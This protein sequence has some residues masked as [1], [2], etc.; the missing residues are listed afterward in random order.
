[1]SDY[2]ARVL[3]LPKQYETYDREP[4]HRGLVIAG[5]AGRR[6]L[7]VQFAYATYEHNKPS[8]YSVI[9]V[10]ALPDGAKVQAMAKDLELCIK[11]RGVANPLMLPRAILP[12]A[13]SCHPRYCHRREHVCRRCRCGQ[14]Q[15]G[16]LG[17]CAR[18]HQDKLEAELEVYRRFTLTVCGEASPVSGPHGARDVAPQVRPGGAHCPHAPGLVRNLNRTRDGAAPSLSPS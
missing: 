17:K 13:C 4:S 14:C 16:G 2:V 11:G 12:M 8:G 18:D 1:M 6:A 5:K 3:V 9:A 10:L 15:Q 7:D